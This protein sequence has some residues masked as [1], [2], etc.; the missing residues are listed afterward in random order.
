MNKIFESINLTL[1]QQGIYD[2]IVSHIKT[3]HYSI[4][5]STDIEEYQLSLTGAAGTGKTF[6]TT[7]IVKALELI[8]D[9]DVIVTAPTHKAA[10]VLTNLFKKNNLKST[11]RTIHSF[12]G[13]KPFIDYERGIETFKPDKTSKNKA[14][15]NILIVDE[16]S[17]IGI[18]LYEYILEAIEDQRV[19]IVLFVGDPN[20]LL[21]ING[22][23]SHIYQLKY[24]YKLHDIVRQAENSSI[25]LLANKIKTM[26]ETKTY[27]PVMEF[28]LKNQY[29]DI[30]YFFNELEFLEDFYKKEKWYL[31]DQIIASHTNKDVDAF[32]KLVRNKFWAQ[33][34]I[35]ELDT[36]REG[37]RLRFNDSYSVNVVSLYHNGE[38]IELE[39]ASK[40]YHDILKIWFWE[41]KSKNSMHQQ[42]FRVVDKDSLKIFNDKLTMIANL[43]KRERFPENKKIWKI[44]FQTR[45][46][47]ANVQ[48]VFSSTIHKLQGSTYRTSYVNLF[49]LAKNQMSLDQKYRLIYVAITRASES[50]KIFISKFEND[51]SEF[52]VE[53]YF[54]NLDIDLED[55]FN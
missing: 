29:E 26:I 27:I 19:G 53:K 39:S 38:E 28:F 32:N 55:I 45:D 4:L 41:C 30:E 52:S 8:D 6:L 50:L 5:K 10:S 25:I 14:V 2:K 54:N 23:N 18:E 48:Y 35:T 34:G 36:L 1:H 13:I 22:E 51:Y 3:S 24:Q 49:D 9:I 17:M 42:V 16:S 40:R 12:L 43:A 7:Q 47:F 20:Q 31:E 46:M 15:T 37:D 44:F 11:A 21:P 33:K